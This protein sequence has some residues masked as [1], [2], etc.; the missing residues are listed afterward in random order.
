MKLIVKQSIIIITPWAFL[1]RI[2]MLITLGY[3]TVYLYI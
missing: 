1:I 3:I 2:I